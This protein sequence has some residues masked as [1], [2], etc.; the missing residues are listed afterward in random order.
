MN[1]EELCI[2]NWRSI[3][4]LE[5][6]FQDLMIFIGQ[7]NHGKSNVLSALLFFFGEIKPH[8]LDF[9]HG[10]EELYVETT[11]S[12]LDEN[13]KRTFK[14]YLTSDNK[15]K[16]RKTAFAGGSFEYK[17]YIQNPVEEWLQEASASEY[18]KREVAKTLPFYPY[19][20]PEGRLTKQEVIDAQKKYIE[21]N[22]EAVELRFQ[23]EETNF[24][25]LKSVAKG[26]FGDVYFIPAIRDA[27]DDFSS[28][29]ASAFGKLYTNIID[30]L[31]STNPE[32]KETK[33]KL[34]TLFG[35]LNR[36][37]CDGKDNKNRPKELEDFER[38]LGDELKSW[39]AEIDVEVTPPNIEEVFRANTQ[40]WVNDGV[41]TDIKRKG[42][43][44]QR[45]LTFA[46]IKVVS[47]TL[48]RERSADSGGEETSGSRMVS[49]S[50][51]FILEEPE[52][53][54][55]PQA[56]R[57]L[58]DSLV[59][60]SESK[61]QV[62]LCTHSSA[63]I[64]VEKY[65]SICIVKKDDEN[66]GTKVCQCSE[67]LFTGDKKKDFNLSYWINP[68]R[69]ELFFARRVILVE[70]PTD[71]TIIPLLAK[72]L[73]VFRYDYT[74]VDCGSKNNIPLYCQL[75]NKF[76]IPYLA[77]YDKDHQASKGAADIAT[78]DISSAR[79]EGAIDPTVGSTLQFV[80]D[81]EEEIGIL[82]GDKNKPY[83]ALTH[84][85][86]AD[87]ALPLSLQTKVQ[88]IFQ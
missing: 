68:D 49:A 74:L 2:C 41:R 58:F 59:A 53:Y 5:I 64:D 18:A 76:R 83:A 28:K 11:F 23:M 65:K 67:D 27:S 33:N 14:K 75:L 15:L 37:D 88:T 86:S 20:P 25:G 1:I 71:K 3:K 80:N 36:L 7:N 52:L 32:W 44:L 55:H 48:K 17:G 62:M 24:L 6:K 43:G 50:T 66:I 34:S 63:L 85:S 22:K 61:N 35:A 81:I 4:N 57:A 82:A 40:V 51:Y 72:R 29:E 39:S 9:N 21:D 70:G 54:L 60:L 19:L 87:F 13:D 69:S 16:V 10:S 31:S 79:I 38:A 77:V 78:A 47:D 26:I 8:D 73:G 84:V 45:A 30:S 56:Q 42:H 12:D 46:L